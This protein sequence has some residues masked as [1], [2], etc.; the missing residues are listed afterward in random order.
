MCCFGTPNSRGLLFWLIMVTLACSRCN[1]SPSNTHKLG[2]I[3][4]IIIW[5]ELSRSSTTFLLQCILDFSVYGY[6][7]FTMILSHLKFPT[8]SSLAIIWN[9][10]RKYAAPVWRPVWLGG[11]ALH[12]LIT[13]T[14]SFNFMGR[15]AT[16]AFSFL[17]TSVFL[18]HFINSLTIID[19][20][21]F[22]EIF[23]KSHF[24]N[25]FGMKYKIAFWHIL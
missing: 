3:D 12:L 14:N 15:L 19:F 17:L 13:S 25:L 7:R 24:I 8:S 22:P 4:P 6:S 9:W 21:G 11:I 23:C 18:I 16:E 5:L 20:V 1:T 2:S 10:N